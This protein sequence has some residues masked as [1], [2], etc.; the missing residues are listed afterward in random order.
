MLQH[1]IVPLSENLCF[2]SCLFKP[3]PLLE[4]Q[5]PVIGQL[6][7]ACASTAYRVSSLLCDVLTSTMTK[8]INY[9]NVW[10]GDIIWCHHVTK[11]KVGPLTR[12][13]RSIVFCGGEALLLVRTFFYAFLYNT[14]KEREKKKS[15]K[16]YWCPLKIDW[17][18]KLTLLSLCCSTSPPHF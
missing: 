3:L 9:A 5:S 16:A 13:F 4:T 14:M 7:H 2:G 17:I 12:C 1:Y 10:L 11:S 6:T 8:S 15:K 18:M